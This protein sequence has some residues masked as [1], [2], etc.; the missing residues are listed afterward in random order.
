METEREK[1]IIV[2]IGSGNIYNFK[3]RDKDIYY[4]DMA[5][6]EGFDG[7][8]ELVY[9][10]KEKEVSQDVTEDSDTTL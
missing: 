5:E 4:F 2:R 1:K 3:Q 10:H 9:E 8:M 6:Q 7:L